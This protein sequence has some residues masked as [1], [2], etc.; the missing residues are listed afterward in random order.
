MKDY[1]T[2][3]E[4]VFRR[5]DEV[6]EENKTRRKKLTEIGVSAACWAA[7][8]AV[9]FGVWKTQIDR[10]TVNSQDVLSGTEQK[11]PSDSIHSDDLDEYLSHPYNSSGH[12]NDGINSTVSESKTNKDDNNYDNVVV[13]IRCY[14]PIHGGIDGSLV[15]DIMK[16][17]GRISNIDVEIERGEYSPEN[18]TAVIANSLKTAVEKYGAE[19][20]HGELDYHVL[21]EYYKDGKPIEITKVLWESEYDRGIQLNFESYSS[22]WGA[23]YEHHI[24]SFMTVSDIES[25]KPSEEYGYVLYLYDSYFGYPYELMDNIIN[26]LYNNG[27]YIE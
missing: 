10:K 27:V 15:D 16:M 8:G 1:K 6:I 3:A 2:V 11:A 20:S 17:R 25:F 4:D 26:G 5:R 24:W 22:D 23:T 21:I 7:V 18:G 12:N 19:D 13:D 14:P 9:G